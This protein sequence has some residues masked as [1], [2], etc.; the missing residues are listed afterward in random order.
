MK[1]RHLF[2]NDCCVHAYEFG[3]HRHPTIVCL[4]GLGNSGAVFS[5]VAEC[6]AKDFH[7]VSFDQPGHGGTSP[8]VH[9]ENY[10]F[11]NLAK[12]YQDV[13]HQVLKNPFYILG[14]SWGADLALHYAK[15]DPDTI[16][17]VIL[18]DGGYTFPDFQENMTFS[19]AYDGW[20]DYMDHSSVFDDWTN[21]IREYQQY[22]DR[23]NEK[24]EQMVQ[25]LFHKKE[26]YE[27]ISS[28]F[29]VVSI[30]KA[31]YKESFTT[32]Y[33]YIKSPLMLIHATL[34]RELQNA[35]RTGIHTLKQH[36]DDLTIVPMEGTGHMVH[37]DQ[38]EK[39]A[40]EIRDWACRG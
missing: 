6:L 28:K 15:N 31:F 40:S 9:E 20:N 32:A 33:P 36:I 12:W 10:Q 8:F 37:W 19:N 4:H 34:P 22:T 17:G 27:L 14:H 38:P 39:V 35:R 11:S 16:K 21:V 13:F 5:E 7:I 1:T 25:T 29:T 24:K 26:H 3:D 2:V 18:L 23:W 30:I